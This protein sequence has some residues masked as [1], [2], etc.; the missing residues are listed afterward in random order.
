MC[1]TQFIDIKIDVS[2]NVVVKFQERELKSVQK[3]KNSNYYNKIVINFFDS[4]FCSVKVCLEITLN[5]GS[6]VR[7]EKL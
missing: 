4:L 2:L 6:L 5:E 7:G 3:Y 1:L